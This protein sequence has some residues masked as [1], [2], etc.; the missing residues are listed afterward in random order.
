MAFDGSP[1]VLSRDLAAIH[2]L[3]FPIPRQK[4]HESG[5]SKNGQEVLE[6]RKLEE[7]TLIARKDLLS[8]S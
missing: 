1:S 4:W 5:F 7:S 8:T 3:L 2:R 6:S